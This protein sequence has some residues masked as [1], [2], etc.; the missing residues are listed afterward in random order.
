MN[1]ARTIFV[2]VLALA[3]GAIGYGIGIAQNVPALS[4][5]AP[6]AGY[7]Y[8]WHFGFFPFF[9]L[10]FPLLFFFLIF[11]LARAAFW[12]G[13]PY[14]HGPMW[15]SRYERF[16]EMHRQMHQQPPGGTDPNAPRT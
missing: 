4:A 14:G 8:P 11:A 3:A 5:G 16:E 1:T 10:L 7:W 15:S 9:G 2:L 6:A 12:G 13:R